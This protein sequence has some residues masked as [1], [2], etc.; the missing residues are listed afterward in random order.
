MDSK[1]KHLVFIVEIGKFQKFFTLTKVQGLLIFYYTLLSK[2][3]KFFP[4]YKGDKG[5]VG[6]T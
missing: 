4:F 5:W 1:P 2:F 6:S 3:A